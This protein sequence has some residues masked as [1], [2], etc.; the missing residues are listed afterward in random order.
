MAFVMRKTET[1][2]TVITRPEWCPKK[3]GSRYEPTDEV[4]DPMEP[5]EETVRQ[6]AHKAFVKECEKRLDME[7]EQYKELDYLKQNFKDQ[8]IGLQKK[9][10]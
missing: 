8:I 9:G 7:A 3:N 5:E 10:D 2:S 6:K 4:V 1:Y